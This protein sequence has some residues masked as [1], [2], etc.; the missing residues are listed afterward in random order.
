MSAGAIGYSDRVRALFQALEGAGDLPQ[1]AGLAV[2]G[3]AV[4]LDRLAWVRFA[5]RIEGGRV[6]ECRFQAFGCPHTLAAASL[7]AARLRGAA[8]AALPTLDAVELGRELEAPAE[9]RG[10]LLVVEDAWQDLL[11]GMRRVQ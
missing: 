3:E 5:A 10:R 8:L 9:K 2:S 4:A 7:A 11:A 1:A 6:S